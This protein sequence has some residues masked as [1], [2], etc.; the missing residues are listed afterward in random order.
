MPT[1]TLIFAWGDDGS[2]QCMGGARSSLQAVVQRP[3]AV[4]VPNGR[5]D[6][7]QLSAGWEQSFVVSSRGRLWGGGSNRGQCIMEGDDGQAALGIQRVELEHV[8]DFDAAALSAGREHFVAVDLHGTKLVTW[9]CSNE[10][11]QTGQGP[12]RVGLGPCTPR[13][14]AP[15]PG[16]RIHA[17]SCGQD[18]TLALTERGEV[19][20]WGHNGV[21]Q[22]GLVGM[23]EEVAT[24]PS[25]QKVDFGALRGLPIRQIAAGAQHSMALGVSGQVLCWGCNRRGRLGLGPSYDAAVVKLPALVEDLPGAARSVAAGG[26]HSAVILRKGRVLLAGENRSGQLGHPPAEVETSSGLFLELPFKDYALRVRAVALGD[27]HTLLL[28]HAGELFGMGANDRAQICEPV[29]GIVDTPR[30]LQL[31]HDEFI[32]WAVAAGPFHSLVLAS[33]PPASHKRSLVAIPEGSLQ[34][35]SM[36]AALPTSGGGSDSDG[37]PLQR[38][39]AFQGV[40]PTKEIDA[41][42]DLGHNLIAPSLVQQV[43]EDEATLESLRRSGCSSKVARSGNVVVPLTSKTGELP[44]TPTEDGVMLLRPV[45]RPGV[46]S[47]TGFMCLSMPELADLVNAIPAEGAPTDCDMAAQERLK[48]TVAGVLRCPPALA[49]SFLFP[50]LNEAK[51]NASALWEQI[52]CIRSRLSRLG[53]QEEA[54]ALWVAAALQG[55]QALAPPKESSGALVYLQTKDQIRALVVYLM[56]PDW[57]SAL[58][59]HPQPG[60]PLPLLAFTSGTYLLQTISRLPLAGRAAFRDIVAEECGDVAVFRDAILPAARALAGAALRHSTQTTRLERSVWDGVFLLQL[61]LCAEKRRLEVASKAAQATVGGQSIVLSRS[62]RTSRSLSL[63]FSRRDAVDSSGLGVTPALS[64][65]LNPSCFQLDALLNSSFPAEVEL[66]LFQQ[67]AKMKV[68]D[69][70]ELCTETRWEVDERGVLPHA[71]MSFMANGSVIPVA[72]KQRVLQVENTMRQQQEQQQLLFT[73]G[74]GLVHISPQGRVQVQAAALFFVLRVRRDHLLH[75][76]SVVLQNAAPQDLRRPLKVQFVGEEGVDEGGVAKEYFRLLS[77][78]IFAPEYAMFRMDP[79]SRYL[80]FDPASPCEHEDF[81][82][83]GAVLGLSVYNNLPGLDVNFPPALYKKLKNTPLEPEDFR[84][85]YPSHAESLQA[86]EDWTPPAGMSAEEADKLFQDTFCLDFSVSYEAFGETVTVALPPKQSGDSA[87]AE[88]PRPKEGE[89]EP[90]TLPRRAEFADAF[91]NWYLV[92][93]VRAQYEGFQRG[94]SRICGSPVFDSLSAAELEAIVAGEKDLDFAGLRR[95]SQVVAST[96]QFYEGYVEGFWKILDDFDALQKRQFLNFVTGSHLAPIGGLERLALKVQRNGGEP[97]N[98]LPTSHTCFN[99]L[100]LPEYEN[101]DKLRRLLI[102][103][104]SNADG[105]GLE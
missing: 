70:T 42:V 68:L 13:C 104:I 102:T 22:L 71:L 66:G 43:E 25:P 99:L 69:P 64:A 19:F 23:N 4:R 53:K 100:L 80:W 77:G 49:A 51:L 17:V 18:H 32:I 83:V 95:G 33:Q 15:Q 97:T 28:S 90:V 2:G 40:A 8:E 92:E 81:W 57:V 62:L 46:A 26:S 101:F 50:A 56:I 29:G 67:H 52:Q 73:Q 39:K 11:G 94:F 24:E 9:G 91:R 86:V 3:T 93:G 31:P 89:T 103:A 85:L 35:R 105:F 20:A 79:D 58:T 48:S 47:K 21:G 38:T 78:Q 27:Q 14:F 61:L 87:T 10:F 59:D 12:N 82:V 72:F 1:S 7:V 76:T 44:K 5:A 65:A 63:T 30:R 45:V 74:P 16:I 88:A 60:G 75:D 84:R 98:Q 55:A 41:T 34:V 6:F 96:V 36:S 54:N 37:E